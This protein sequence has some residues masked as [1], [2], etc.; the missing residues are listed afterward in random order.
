MNKINIEDIVKSKLD[1]YE[2]PYD[3]SWNEFEKKLNKNKVSYTKYYIAAAAI[4]VVGLLSIP[5]LN[6]T[7]TTDQKD[8]KDIPLVVSQEKNMSSNGTQI[9]S[10]E[11]EEIVSDNIETSNSI[12]TEVVK[13]NEEI[14][15]SDNTSDNKLEKENVESENVITS[16]ESK[17]QNDELGEEAIV[18]N[19]A[20]NTN[21]TNNISA[22]FKANTLN[23]CEPLTVYFT[24]E[25]TEKAEY[26]WK[27]SDGT[28]SNEKMPKHIFKKAGEYTVELVVKSFDT[29]KTVKSVKEK[30]IVVNPKPKAVF[31]MSNDNNIYYFDCPNDYTDVKWTINSKVISTELDPE[32][33]F[34]TIGKSEITLVVENEFHCKASYSENVNIEP[35]F[36]IANAF[37]PNDNGDNELFGPVFESL[38][39]YKYFLYI[40]DAYGKLIFKSNYANQAWNGRANNTNSIAPDGTYVWKLVIKDNY[41]NKQTKKGQ[42]A[43]RK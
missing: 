34:K 40:Y 1:N 25:N 17:E 27:F 43:L 5:F 10:V 24:P 11:N 2:M 30:Y 41:G 4:I 15:I 18:A 12:I 6:I 7:K 29:E 23:G 35:V 3:N 28:V 42:V 20:S 22:N 13:E 9:A 38:D 21:S 14:Q 39:N 37:T 33:E 36:Q 31:T 16:D 19:D 26:L 32:Y 8:Q